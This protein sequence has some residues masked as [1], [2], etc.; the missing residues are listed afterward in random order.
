MPN[1]DV[2]QISLSTYQ[3][4]TVSTTARR[5]LRLWNTD[6]KDAMTHA[7]EIFGIDFLLFLSCTESKNPPEP[8][9]SEQHKGDFEI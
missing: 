7:S 6:P 2:R 9:A 5:D 3:N 4:S 8:A 1:V